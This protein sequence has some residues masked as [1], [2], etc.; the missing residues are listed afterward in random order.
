M[1]RTS[2]APHAL[3]SAGPV[4]ALLQS[5]ARRPYP[6]VPIAVGA[7]ALYDTDCEQAEALA[8]ASATLRAGEPTPGEPPRAVVVTADIF[9][10]G[11]PV[12]IAWAHARGQKR[13]TAGIEVSTGCRWPG[14]LDDDEAEKVLKMLNDAW[15]EAYGS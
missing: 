12:S 5:L 10:D 11:C 14:Q 4:G 13:V 7:P 8:L 2:A 15:Q 1:I 9:R 3:P 6:R